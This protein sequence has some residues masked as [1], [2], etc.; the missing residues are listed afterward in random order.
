MQEER[1]RVPKDP[2]P[3]GFEEKRR[4]PRRTGDEPGRGGQ[5]PRPRHPGQYQPG[6]DDDDEFDPSKERDRVHR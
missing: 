4:T 1:K 6:S 2:Q 3:I 5:S